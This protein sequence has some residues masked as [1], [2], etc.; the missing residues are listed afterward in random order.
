[1]TFSYDAMMRQLEKASAE[2]DADPKLRAA[3]ER[4][5]Q[6]RAEEAAK[7]KRQPHPLDFLDVWYGTSHW[8]G[9]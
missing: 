3:A 8:N 6:A 7:P 2:I 4:W 5:R 9:G 1:M